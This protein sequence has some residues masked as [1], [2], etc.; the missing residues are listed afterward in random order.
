[1]HLHVRAFTTADAAGV[2]DWRYPPPYAGYDVDGDALVEVL[3]CYRAVVDA[4]DQLVGFYCTGAAARVP[5]LAVVDGVVDLGMG[6]RPDLVGAGLGRAFGMTAIEHVA[7]EPGSRT[8]RVVVQSWNER[9]LRLA[10]RLGF[11]EAGVHAVGPVEYE[12]L[13]RTP[14]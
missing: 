2:G 6:M 10:R 4:D 8:L 7:T 3:D 5:G 1:V 14:P 9:S 11:S 13:V 12:V